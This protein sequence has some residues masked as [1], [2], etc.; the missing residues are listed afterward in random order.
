MR[1]SARENSARSRFMEG[2]ATDV[3]RLLRAAI[4]QKRLVELVYSNKLRV[5][6][7]HDYGIHK[8]SVKLLAYQVAGFSSGPSAKLALDRRKL[9]L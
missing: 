9:H 6:E 4:E 3:D 2:P 1:A 7:P 5:L 8:G